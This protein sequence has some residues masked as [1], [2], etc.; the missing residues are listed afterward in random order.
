MPFVMLR[1][2]DCEDLTRYRRPSVEGS[3]DG[4]SFLEFQQVDLDY[5]TTLESSRRWPNTTSGLSTVIRLYGVTSSGLSVCAHVHGFKAYFY[6]SVPDNFN[7][8][9]VG[10]F[11]KVRL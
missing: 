2:M 11:R 3:V 4:G 10:A 5:Y 7:V 1:P 9:H 6:S 8:A